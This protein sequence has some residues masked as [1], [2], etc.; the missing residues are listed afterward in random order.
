MSIDTTT[1]ASATEIMIR[2][3]NM[4]LLLFVCDIVLHDKANLFGYA[5]VRQGITIGCNEIGYSPGVR[6]PSFDSIPSSSVTTGVVDW[7]AVR[8]VNSLPQRSSFLP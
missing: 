2:T 7:I 8:R 4:R 5:N 3:A 1:V 6:E